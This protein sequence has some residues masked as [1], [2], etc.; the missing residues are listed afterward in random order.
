MESVVHVH[1]TSYLINFS[2]LAFPHNITDT[3]LQERIIEARTNEDTPVQMVVLKVNPGE[4]AGIVLDSISV[5]SSSDLGPIVVSVVS[6]GSVA[7]LDGRLGRGDQVLE[8]NGHS[9][10]QASLERARYIYSVTN[11][12]Y[13]N[14]FSLPDGC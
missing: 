12:M 2:F 10:R 8:I 7:A 6:P 9:L 13:H 4:K 1:L 5:H 11:C 14:T 3:E